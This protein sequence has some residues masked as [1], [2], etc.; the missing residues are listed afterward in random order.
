V[1]DRLLQDVKKGGSFGIASGRFRVERH[2]TDY[3]PHQI[4]ILLE[5]DDCDGFYLSDEESERLRQEDWTAELA[6]AKEDDA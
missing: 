6:A 2:A 1:I 3:G 5:L 4:E